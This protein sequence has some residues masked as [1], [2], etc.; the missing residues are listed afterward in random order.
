MKN[1]T[2][3]LM[4]LALPCQ[5]QSS[6][7]SDR[8]WSDRLA[9]IDTEYFD[10]LW[11]MNRD[12]QSQENPWY[13]PLVKITS[14]S[15]LQ[16]D[17]CQEFRNACIVTLEQ[18]LVTEKNKVLAEFKKNVTQKDSPECTDI[19]NLTKE[20]EFL[21]KRYEVFIKILEKCTKITQ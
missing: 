13:Q 15:T 2:L 6:E 11:K 3:A 14:G 8:E 21:D 16:K 18:I 7:W 20:L 12:S 4:L 10:M 1:V 17:Q 19:K 9:A 5:A